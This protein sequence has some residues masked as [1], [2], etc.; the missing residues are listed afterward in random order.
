M[1][2][3][4]LNFSPI[5][6]CRPC[7]RDVVLNQIRA[8]LQYGQFTQGQITEGQIIVGQNTV[9]QITWALKQYGRINV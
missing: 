7:M 9:G 2:I 5:C 3:K 6:I 1:S 8:K 4:I